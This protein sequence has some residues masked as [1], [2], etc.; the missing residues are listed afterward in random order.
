MRILG[1]EADFQKCITDLADLCGFWWMHIGDSRK[2][3]KDKKSG[4]KL[5]GDDSTSGWPDLVLF[6]PIRQITLFWEVKNCRRKV[7]FKRCTDDQL[8]TLTALSE[9]GEEADVV[10]P[11]DWEAIQDILIGRH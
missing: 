3:V 8:A 11:E 2:E 9:A 10:C 6:H 7:K 1:S 4:Y 5:V